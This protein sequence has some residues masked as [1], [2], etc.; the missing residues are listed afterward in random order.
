MNIKGVCRPSVK[1]LRF[2]VET[3]YLWIYPINYSFKCFSKSSSNYH[4][5]LSTMAKL[6]YI[7]C[8]NSMWQSYL[9]Q[10]VDDVLV[11]V[12]FSSLW[13]TFRLTYIWIPWHFLW[14]L[15]QAMTVPFSSFHPRVT[16]V[17]DLQELVC[18]YMPLLSPW[19]SFIKLIIQHK[20]I[21]LVNSIHFVLKPTLLKGPYILTDLIEALLGNISVNTVQHALRN[22]RGSCI[23]CVVRAERIYENMGIWIQ[24]AVVVRLCLILHSM[25]DIFN[26]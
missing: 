9:C 17:R 26:L 19:Q 7:F 5:R 2:C 6:P 8:S 10:I 11:L 20:S 18:R 15:I 13:W 3:L 14:N 21:K 22:K 16:V 12:L 1:I 24:L 4:G 23:L 25:E